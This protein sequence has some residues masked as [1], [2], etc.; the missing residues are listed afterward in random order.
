MANKVHVRRCHVCGEITEAEGQLVEQCH[1]CGKH[2]SPFYYFNER[3]AM[4]LISPQ[5]ADKEYKSS[6]LP[7]REYPPVWGLT[8]YWES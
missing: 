7:L 8:V 4:N 3:L 5:E 6:A 1:H 2:L